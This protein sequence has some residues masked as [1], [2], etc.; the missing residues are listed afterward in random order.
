MRDRSRYRAEVIVVGAGAAGLAVAAVARQ[1]GV[2]PV[3]LEQA[4]DLGGGWPGRWDSLRLHTVRTMSA[5]PDRPIPRS[6]GRWVRRD[7]FVRYLRDYADHF[8]IEPEYGVEVQRLER[9]GAGRWRVHTSS[10]PRESDRVVIATG[11][12]RRPAIPDWPGRAQYGR[13]LLHTTGYREPSAY[14]GRSVLVVGAGNSATEIAADLAQHGVGVQLAVRTPPTI[15]RR[16]TLGVPS[17]LIAVSMRRAPEPVMNTLG[18]AMRRVSVP[19]LRR[20]G[21]SAPADGFSQFLRTGTVPIIDHGFV[22]A[23]L[24]GAIEVVPA[25]RGFVADEVELADGRRLAP[26]AVICGTGFSPGLEPL[27]GHLGVLDDRGDPLV[28]G[29]Q[30]LPSAP[31]LHFVGVSLELTGLLREIGIQARALGAVLG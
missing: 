30:T 31:G 2:R 23:V 14:R 17:Q 18:A 21:L 7:D 4:A 9:T 6:Y 8:D 13:P 26:D 20:H 22:D 15:V 19:D 3:V 11:Y 27:V 16:S 10:G 24:G 12:S 25:V 5:L 1:H 28:G 29:A